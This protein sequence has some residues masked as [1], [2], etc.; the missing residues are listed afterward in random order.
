MGKARGTCEEEEKYIQSFGW[1]NLME[2]NNLECLGV[3]LEIILKWSLKN[4]RA[5]T[6]FV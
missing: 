5:W 1:E 3:H 2:K 6:G 4:T